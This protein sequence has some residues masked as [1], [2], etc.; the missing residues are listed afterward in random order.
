V[1]S[2]FERYRPACGVSRPAPA[3]ANA[4]PALTAGVAFRQ[5]RPVRAAVAQEAP[6]SKGDSLRRAGLGASDEAAEIAGSALRPQESAPLLS[7]D[8]PRSGELQGDSLPRTWRSWLRP[9]A[10]AGCQPP[11]VGS[12]VPLGTLSRKFHRKPAACVR[13]ACDL[14]RRAK[15]YSPSSQASAAESSDHRSALSLQQQQKHRNPLL[16]ADR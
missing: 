13:A 11:V 9:N 7:L 3:G 16:G 4:V 1:V 12:S 2:I 14:V 15:P 8:R 10:L 5:R 6:V